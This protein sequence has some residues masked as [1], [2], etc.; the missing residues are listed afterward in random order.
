M[1]FLNYSVFVQSISYMTESTQLTRVIIRTRKWKW[2]GK[3][4]KRS[5][6]LSFHD[7]ILMLLFAAGK[8]IVISTANQNRLFH[9]SSRITQRYWC[10][11]D[12]TC[13]F[14]AK[15]SR[16]TRHRLIEHCLGNISGV[17][18]SWDLLRHLI[19]PLLKWHNKITGDISNTFNKSSSQ[20]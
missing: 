9:P 15:S 20:K 3:I 19:F 2:L 10:I 18:K 16:K 8:F 4:F 12:K 13:H 6:I 5:M 17:K 11:K 14:L 7:F 1:Y